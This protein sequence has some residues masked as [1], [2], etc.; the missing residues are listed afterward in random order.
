MLASGRVAFTQQCITRAENN[1]HKWLPKALQELA[2]LMEGAGSLLDWAI[3]DPTT[4]QSGHLLQG[5]YVGLELQMEEAKKAS[6][7]I[8]DAVEFIRTNM[9][10]PSMG[11][12][13]AQEAWLGVEFLNIAACILAMLCCN[14]SRNQLCLNVEEHPLLFNMYAPIALQGYNSKLIQ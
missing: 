13:N 9:Q 12:A 4:T 7:A 11:A 6:K 3:K 5:F 1:M 14:D 10:V 8:G 2:T